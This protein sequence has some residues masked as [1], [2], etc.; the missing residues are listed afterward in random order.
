MA[1]H[2]LSHDQL[3]LLAEVFDRV[4]ERAPALDLRLRFGRSAA[5]TI[6]ALESRGYLTVSSRDFVALTPAGKA[7]VKEHA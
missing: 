7:Y 2:T 3:A 5:R 6:A 4:G 1:R